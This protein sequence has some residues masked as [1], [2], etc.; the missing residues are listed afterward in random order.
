MWI[1][2][3]SFKMKGQGHFR[4]IE[5]SF[6]VQKNCQ[7]QGKQQWQTPHCKMCFLLFAGLEQKKKTLHLFETMQTINIVNIEIQM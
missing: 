6:S 5:L 7:L 4:N 2:L 3:V 1:F